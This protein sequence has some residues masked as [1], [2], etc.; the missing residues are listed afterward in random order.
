MLWNGFEHYPVYAYDDD[1]SFSKPCFSKYFAN[2][3]ESIEEA[4][5]WF[6]WAKPYLSD[7]IEKYCDIQTL[8]IQKEVTK[9]ETIQ[10][11]T[12]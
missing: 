4:E 10:K 11:L 8:S 7:Y 2:K 5:E 12:L 3:F 9:Y 1:L 6:E